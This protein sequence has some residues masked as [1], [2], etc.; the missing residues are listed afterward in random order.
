MGNLRDRCMR[1]NCMYG[2]NGGLAAV[3]Q[4][5]YPLT[6][7]LKIKIPLVYQLFCYFRLFIIKPIAPIMIRDK[8]EPII[9]EIVV[10]LL[11]AINDSD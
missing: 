2:D 7:F 3:T 9:P 1:E 10:P 5:F 4:P 6:R 8:I 11:T